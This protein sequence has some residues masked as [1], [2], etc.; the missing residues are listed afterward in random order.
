VLTIFTRV[1]YVKG[2]L[3]L[4]AVERKIGRADVRR[5]DAAVL[6]RPR[7]RGRGRG[8]SG[9]RDPSQ[10]SGYDATAC[11]QTWLAQRAIPTELTCP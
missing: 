11:A 7:R 1:P 10:T 4:R 5:D 2:A 9:R 6:R 8:R 3:F